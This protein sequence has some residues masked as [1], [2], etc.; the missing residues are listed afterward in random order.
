MKKIRVVE[1]NSAIAQCCPS[2]LKRVFIVILGLFLLS[3]CE[4]CETTCPRCIAADDFGIPKSSVSAL[5]ER[6]SLLL[7]SDAE[8][9]GLENN[10]SGNQLMRWEDSGYVTSGEPITLN[11]EGRWLF[12]PMRGAFNLS[13][14]EMQKVFRCG[15]VDYDALKVASE[16][17][18]KSFP[19]QSCTYLPT[20]MTDI[21][22]GCLIN[23]VKID[24][25]FSQSGCILEKGYGLYLLFHR[26]GDPNPN[27][28]FSSIKNP[29][30]PT[31]HVGYTGHSIRIQSI[32]TTDCTHLKLKPGWRIY[33][34]LMDVF[35]QN[36]IG[37]YSLEFRTGV[38][39]PKNTAKFFEGV[40]ST[41]QKILTGQNEA[42]YKAITS[43]NDYVS[44][45]KALIVLM[46]VLTG[47]RF[48]MGMSE[49]PPSEL[50]IKVLKMAVILQLISP[51]SWDFF[52]NNLFRL[53]IDGLNEVIAVV[54]SHTGAGYQP[55]QPFAFLDD[56]VN[57]LFKMLVSTKVKAILLAYPLGVFWWLI[58][59]FILV[60][61]VVLVAYAF[62]VYITALV[63]ISVLIVL[64][65]ILFLGMLFGQLKH[66]FDNWFTQALSFCFQAIMIFTVVSL[67]SAMI[68]DQFYR[69]TGYTVCCNKFWIFP[70]NVS[71]YAWTPGQRFMP[72]SITHMWESK[73][74]EFIGGAKVIDIP[75]HYKE[76]GCRFVDYPF[77]DPQISDV[78]CGIAGFAG[79]GGDWER[80]EQIRE[81]DSGLL[82]MAEVFVLLLLSVIMFHMRDLCQSI[83]ASLV[84]ASPF[85]AVIGGAY[86]AQDGIG[87]L[88][89]AGKMMVGALADKLPVLSRV[90]SGINDIASLRGYIGEKVAAKLNETELGETTM[91]VLST[92]GD[93]SSGIIKGTSYLLGVNS[94]LSDHY[95]EKKAFRQIN[96]TQ[97]LMGY[98]L[99]SIVGS[100][101]LSDSPGIRML[102]GGLK[103]MSDKY[104][105]GAKEES[106]FGGLRKLYVCE[107]E[108]IHDYYLG[109]QREKLPECMNDTKKHQDLDAHFSPSAKG[110]PSMSESSEAGEN[111]PR[112][113][114][115]LPP[116]YSEVEFENTARD[117]LLESTGSVSIGEASPELT[118]R[119]VV[120]ETSGASVG[121][122]S[123]TSGISRE[124]PEDTNTGEASPELT[125]R[126]VVEE[127][128]GASVGE[129]SS[130]SGIS[131]ELPED[132]NTGETGLE[133]ASHSSVQPDTAQVPDNVET[134]SAFSNITQDDGGV[135]SFVRDVLDKQSTYEDPMRSVTPGEEEAKK[136]T[137]KRKGRKLPGQVTETEEETND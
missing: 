132:T 129:E 95:Y 108:K 118:S 96:Y 64:M 104:F 24:P 55:D 1:V 42:I 34:K 121:E 9:L 13:K 79:K 51:S 20:Q 49:S 41:L 110:G 85:Q 8:V 84:G 94:E 48:L 120:E 67:F 16:E 4:K 22:T 89:R 82:D 6:G 99:V 3:G 25:K 15:D 40:R 44:L 111:L 122:E 14:D 92:V 134:A 126:T 43:N 50:L 112:H 36:N 87:G 17:F 124:L 128:S 23:G 19:R 7:K 61:Y 74:V 88:Y 90:R 27:A 98:H 103:H 135:F 2:A 62:V 39:D 38:V 69:N 75:P 81:S 54:N 68:K 33:Y 12:I 29:S 97:A 123:S 125:S 58:L 136:S 32:F 73:R 56:T 72:L 30:S 11:V 93:V 76:K 28:T 117:I 21:T 31:M 77:Y 86:A 114:N 18:R 53:F 109:I 52:Y 115:S 127:T 83:G 63:G 26:P 57:I 113:P 35:Y 66:T 91:K 71:V 10:T 78:N 105:V 101:D 131:R 80:I 106:L 45:V 137:R 46:I 65:P 47:L 102:F 59:F 133:S 37:G 116:S 100:R 60:I 70:F 119:T 130:T 5:I 107:R